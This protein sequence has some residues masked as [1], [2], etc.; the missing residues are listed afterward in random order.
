[1]NYHPFSH[2]NDEEFLRYVETSIDSLTSTDLEL[3][4]IR[5]FTP[6][7]HCEV[8]LTVIKELQHQVEMLE[9]EL[10]EAKED[11]DMTQ[12][13]LSNALRK[14]DQYQSVFNRI[15]TIIEEEK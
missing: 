8:D 11:L 2:L 10:K 15:K 9:S 12:I 13:D 5:R 7:A 3:E 4:L 6:H 14:I 1:M